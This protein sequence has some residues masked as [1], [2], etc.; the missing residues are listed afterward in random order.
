MFI[1]WTP[2][3]RG[4]LDEGSNPKFFSPAEINIISCKVPIHGHLT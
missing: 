4:V 2:Q 1:L 3:D